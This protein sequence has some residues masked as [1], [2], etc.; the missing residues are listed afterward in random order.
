VTPRTR[1]D[2]APGILVAVVLS[3]SILVLSG[4]PSPL[5]AQDEQD[6]SALPADTTATL[7]GV[8]VSAMTGG[9]LPNARVVLVKS[10]YGA[11]ADSTGAFRIPRVPP[12]LDTVEVSLIGY[13]SAR[14]P[15]VLQAGATT[16]ATFSLSETV[17]RVEELHVTVRQA[18]A[19]GKLARFEEHKRHGMGY[20]IT[21]SMV[22]DRHARHSSDLLRMVPGLEVGPFNLGHADVRVVRATLNC[23][24]PIYV[25][26]LLSPN[27]R[28]DDVDPADVMAVEVYR[29]PS[30]T[31]AEYERGRNNCGAIVVWTQQGGTG[32]E[33]GR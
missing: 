6:M 2:R 23:N 13:A 4:S 29:G 17:L 27:L 19:M 15:I 10:G 3:M 8:V 9:R 21:P 7:T 11:F 12:G 5:R 1:F 20:Y 16:S 14:A 31:P 30:E 26:G 33:G 18:A 24:P 25:D 22:A 32:D 28:I